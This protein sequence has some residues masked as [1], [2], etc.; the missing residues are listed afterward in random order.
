MAVRASCERTCEWSVCPQS[1][2]KPFDFPDLVHALARDGRDV[3]VY[4]YSGY[5]RDLGRHEDYEAA[6]SEWLDPAI[7]ASGA[8]SAS[9]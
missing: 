4:R 1:D 3:G 2:P 6:N 9:L 8:E 7:R 5:W